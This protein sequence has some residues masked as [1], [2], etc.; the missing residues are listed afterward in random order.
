MKLYGSLTSPFVRKIRIAA[1]E[2]GLGERVELVP[3]DP[4]S[5]PAELIAGNP[6]CKVPALLADDGLVLPDSEL[7]MAY[8]LEVSGREDRGA[9][10]WLLAR[11]AQLADGILDAAVAMVIEKR[12][13]PEVIYQPWLDRQT[14]AIDRSLDAL[15]AEA[16]TLRSEG[17]ARKLEITLGA[18]LGYVEFR[19]PAYDWRATRPRLAAWYVAFSQRPSM[20][21][22]QPPKA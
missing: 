13:P 3:T 6:L 22:T 18:A 5:S 19:M 21:S 9:D 2:L 11:L 4:W 14:A 10:R 7:I 17:E 1:V 15:E 20:Q 12:R 8:L 16:A